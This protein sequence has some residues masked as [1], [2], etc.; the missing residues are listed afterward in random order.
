[1]EKDLASLAYR[2]VKPNLWAKPFGSTVILFD[3]DCNVMS[4]R[5]FGAN[6]KV[7]VYSSELYEPDDKLYNSLAEFIQFFETWHARSDIGA[8][9][10]QPR[11]N[12]GFLTLEESL[13]FG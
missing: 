1:M 10:N 9:G 4:Q 11:K 6:G 2:R 3:T 8:Y 5:F 12:L 13:L 7:L